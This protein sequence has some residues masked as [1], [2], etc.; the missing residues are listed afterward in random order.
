MRPHVLQLLDD[1]EQVADRAGEAVEPDH[2]QGVAGLDGAQQ[3]GQDRAAAV[4]AGGVFLEDVGAAGRLQ[5]IELRIRAL[6]LY[7]CPVP[8]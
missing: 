1:G 5:L 4:G 6:F 2:D 3:A 7:P 8:L